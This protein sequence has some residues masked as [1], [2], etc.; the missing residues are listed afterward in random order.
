M[1][2][3]LQTAPAFILGLG[4]NG[5][6]HA[7]SLARA[8]VPALGFYYSRRHFGRSSRL[9]HAYPVARSLS[10]EGL[11]SILIE[12]A[13]RF[14]G[15]PVLFAA[16]D[17][18]AFL[19]A[20]AREH[21][22]ERFAFHWNFAETVL[23]LF[24]KAEMIRFCQQ[25][26]I[27]CPKTHVTSTAEDTRLAAQAFSF[28][29]VVKP[30]RS[31]RTAFPSGRKNY[32]AA[33]AQ[34]LL[35]FYDQYPDLV[36]A[37]LW[38]EVI[39]GPDEEIYQC[40]VLVAES[41][42]VRQICGVR[43]LRQYPRGFGNM[44]FGRT[45]TNGIVVLESLRLLRF[46][47]YRGFASIEFKRRASDNRYYF[48]EMNARLPRY[49]GLLADAGVNL[50]HLGYLDLTPAARRCDPGVQQHDNV[51]WLTAGEDFLSVRESR[52]LRPRAWLRWIRSV[53]QA[54]SFAWWDQRDPL[55][56]L[57]SIL[58]GRASAKVHRSPKP[59]GSRP[60]E[61]A[62]SERRRFFESQYESP[63]EVDLGAETFLIYDIIPSRLKSAVPILFC[64]GWMENPQNHKE[65][66]YALYLEGRRMIFPDSPH[67]IEP[68]HRGSFRIAELR[69]AAVLTSTLRLRGISEVDAIAHSEGAINLAI[70]ATADGA[71]R[72]RNIV[73]HSPAGLCGAG[74]I[75]EGAWRAWQEARQERRRQALQA[76]E[77]Q[78]FRDPRR[79][80]MYFCTTLAQTLAE[81]RA[82]AEADIRDMLVYL[83]RRGT[84]IAIIHGADD[85]LFRMEEMQKHVDAGMVDG[86]YSVEGGHRQIL[87]EP[88]RHARLASN[89]LLALERKRD[90]YHA[91]C[92][93][94]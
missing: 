17:E 85:R 93:T 45:E 92:M 22:A 23:K 67:G 3:E 80:R 28:P 19:V 21:L 42:A 84:G 91:V 10:A 9:L 13:A 57:H 94:R 64:P 83:R 82:I 12:T 5:Y 47:R 87:L 44:C 7:R 1:A 75:L 29:C 68:E 81:A 40:N 78:L 41:G 37:T 31:F 69:K 25:A 53:S 6:G 76:T 4:P 32:V 51:Y 15:R 65:T 20:Q 24:D 61:R 39:D 52:G 11:A 77:R 16:S 35:Q 72:F 58:K 30:L 74:N 38:Q 56:F 71:P 59:S 86:F 62:H 27:L 50:P 34:D 70:A 48:I 60:A 46:L 18:F 43:K 8:G 54:R 66:I 88:T 73:L 89:A 14:R 55:P 26:G 33:S 90:Q 36:G 49:C 79:R 63:D 2:S